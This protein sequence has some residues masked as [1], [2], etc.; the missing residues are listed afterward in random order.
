MTMSGRKRKSLLR[1]AVRGIGMRCGRIKRQER[2]EKREAR[3]ALD[4]RG[5]L[6]E[7]APAR[8]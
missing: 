3:A 2:R 6:Q 4:V 5:V 1:A 8:T 7:H